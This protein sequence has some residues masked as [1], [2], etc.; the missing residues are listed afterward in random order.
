MPGVRLLAAAATAVT[1]YVHAVMGSWLR[2]AV[3]QVAEPVVRPEVQM[4]RRIASSMV[5][6]SAGGDAWV[7]RRF[8]T[9][10]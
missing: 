4:S 1:G 2:A 9:F 8:R 7:A 10:Q 6:V 3:G 5:S